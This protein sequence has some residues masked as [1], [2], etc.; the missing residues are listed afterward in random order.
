MH[1]SNLLFTLNFFQIK[2]FNLTLLPRGRFTF[3]NNKIDPSIPN[4]LATAALRFGHS[5]IRNTFIRIAKDLSQFPA[6]PTKEFLNPEFLYET[7]FGGLDSIIRGMA[8][9]EANEVDG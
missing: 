3:Y 2:F 1:T 7:E 6:I 4:S 8:K 9:D 5:T